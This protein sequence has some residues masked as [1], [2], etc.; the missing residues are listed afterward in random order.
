MDKKCLNI[1]GWFRKSPARAFEEVFY[2]CSN[3]C[4]LIVVFL[5]AEKIK[6]IH[7]KA[8]S[9]VGGY[10]GS[11]PA[12]GNNFAHRRDERYSSEMCSL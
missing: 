8:G 10:A 11:N 1:M 12:Q 2:H 7:R 3:K 6:A 9:C 5:M 4:N